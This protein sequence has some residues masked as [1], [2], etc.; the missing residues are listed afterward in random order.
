[1]TVT[2]AAMAEHGMHSIDLVVVNLYAFRE[3]CAKA[4]ACQ[5]AD[6]RREHRHRRADDD[7]QR[8]Q[9]SRST[10]ASSSDPG[11]YDDS[12]SA[13]RGGTTASDRVEDASCACGQGV[14]AHIA[15]YDTAI[16][17]WFAGE[18]RRRRVPRRVV[19]DRRRQE[20]PGAALRR[21]SAPAGRVLSATPMP[22]AEPRR[23]SKQL[24]G[25][26]LSYNNILD[27][28]AALEV[29]CGTWAIADVWRSSSTRIRAE[30]P[31]VHAKDIH[32]AFQ[33]CPTRVIRLSAYGGIA[34]FNRSGDTRRNR[35]RAIADEAE[36]FFEV[37]VAP[38]GT[39]RD[40]ARDHPDR[41]RSG[42]SQRPDSRGRI[43]RGSTPSGMVEQIANPRWISWWNA[44]R[45]RMRPDSTAWTSKFQVRD[46]DASLRT[47][48]RGGRI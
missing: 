43:S 11:D 15:S 28:D 26:E 23:R 22:D 17:S 33:R 35:A 40:S 37:I 46:Q 41:E 9:E 31:T 2:C 18:R 25:K 3:T 21:E 20:D 48:R 27:L 6:S 29:A 4:K 34:A 7:P 12:W 14:R 19:R 5:R 16:G 30:Q 32:E 44:R 13:L 10:S 8:G 47:S 24:S 42:E 38:G 1:M 36:K 39:R 45:R